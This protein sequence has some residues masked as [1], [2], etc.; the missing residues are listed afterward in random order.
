[1]YLWNHCICHAPSGVSS[2][3][4]LETYFSNTSPWRVVDKTYGLAFDQFQPV[5]SECYAY[6]ILK[7][8]Y[9]NNTIDT[10]TSDHFR[11]SKTSIIINEIDDEVIIG[12]MWSGDGS[13]Y[14]N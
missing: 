9:A 7:N 3:K 10:E 6:T 11:E 14:R 2:Q 13:D 12:R 8:L 4:L 1:M 5:N